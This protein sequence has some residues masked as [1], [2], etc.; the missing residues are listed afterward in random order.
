MSEAPN[1]QVKIKYIKLGYWKNLERGDGGRLDQTSD[2]ENNACRTIFYNSNEWKQE[3]VSKR[4]EN[5][6][7][8]DKTTDDGLDRTVFTKPGTDRKV[9][10]YTC[11]LDSQSN[12]DPVILDEKIGTEGTSLIKLI[13]KDVEKDIDELNTTIY[14]TGDFNM[15]SGPLPK[16]GD[17]GPNPSAVP[18]NN[19]LDRFEKRFTYLIR[20]AKLHFHS[21]QK[22]KDFGALAKTR[23]LYPVNAQLLLKKVYNKRYYG[24]DF[25]GVI[26]KNSGAAPTANP[27]VPYV[28]FDIEPSTLG[29]SARGATEFK[30]TDVPYICL[31]ENEKINLDESWISD[32]PLIKATHEYKDNAGGE[33]VV[34]IGV[35]NVLSSGV[36]KRV[37]NK[38]NGKHILEYYNPDF[39]KQYLQFL[40]ILTRSLL[41]GD[42]VVFP[43]ASKDP[44][45]KIIENRILKE[46]RP[47]TKEKTD[48]ILKEINIKLEEILE[49]PKQYENNETNETRFKTLIYALVDKVSNPDPNPIWVN[50]KENIDKNDLPK[51]GKKFAK[52]LIEQFQLEDMG[53]FEINFVNSNF[54]PITATSNED[55]LIA[56]HEF[57]KQE[58]ET[59]FEDGDFLVCP[60]YDWDQSSWDY[61]WRPP[62]IKDVLLDITHENPEP[63]LV[64]GRKSRR[65]YKR[66]SK[67]N[68]RGRK[69]K[70]KRKRKRSSRR[71]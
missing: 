31:D 44:L 48:D 69:G 41:K 70:T 10:I 1:S 2:R 39:K 51:D 38:L 42:N 24:T 34:N 40:D 16:T 14:L 53:G 6:V 49:L 52:Y 65:V 36:S 30:K 29:N 45:E 35:F 68:R 20:K 63:S 43:D 37:T 55:L 60:E 3:G 15:H 5:M 25:V 8:G 19:Y 33:K 28:D 18:D 66:K 56:K 57:L 50:Y 58:V 46:I 59:F 22:K 47:L 61:M 23:S 9:I 62:Q 26:K 71:L 7:K 13:Q 21:D 54:E 67:K 32:H 11:H 17:S 27:D 64:G 12:P 4:Y